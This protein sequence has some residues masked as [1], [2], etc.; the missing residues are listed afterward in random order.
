LAHRWWDLPRSVGALERGQVEHRDRQPDALLLG[1]R[2]DRPLYEH[3]GA[4]LDAQAVDVWQAADH[5]LSMTRRPIPPGAAMRRPVALASAR[6][7]NPRTATSKQGQK[8]PDRMRSLCTWVM[9]A[10]E[11]ANHHCKG[12]RLMTRALGLLVVLA[13]VTALLAVAPA[14]SARGCRVGDKQSY[15]TTYVLSIKVSGTS[16]RKARRL[17]RAYHR[18]RPGRKGRCRRVKGYSCSERRFNKSATSYDSRV[19]CRRGGKKVKHTYTQFI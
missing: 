13:T 11:W 10:I 16:C 14:A 9:L 3:R 7:L 12:D 18:C 2:L 8:D 4:L 17:I 19:T 15:N 6:G 1:G 5:T